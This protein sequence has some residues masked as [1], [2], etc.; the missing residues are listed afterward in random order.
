MRSVWPQQ[1]RGGGRD[2]PPHHNI[3]PPQNG[4]HFDCPWREGDNGGGGG[5]GSTDRYRRPSRR[6]SSPEQRP[7]P[8]FDGVAAS[9]ATDA[10]CVAPSHPPNRRVRSCYWSVPTD[11]RLPPAIA[12]WAF[13]ASVQARTVSQERSQRLMLLEATTRHFEIKSWNLCGNGQ[14]SL[15]GVSLAGSSGRRLPLGGTHDRTRMT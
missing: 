12:S 15:N 4:P 14:C 5:G 13:A 9:A 6:G 11:C 7:P 2:G 1:G 8:R 3:S 10:G